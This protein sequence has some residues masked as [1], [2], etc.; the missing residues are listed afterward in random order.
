MVRLADVK[1]L[2][3][4]TLEGDLKGLELSMGD[5]EEPSLTKFNI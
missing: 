3:E 2:T 1:C 4:W 5:G